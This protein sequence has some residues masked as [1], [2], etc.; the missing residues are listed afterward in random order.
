MVDILYN[1]MKNLCPKKPRTY[2]KKARKGYLPIA[3]QRRPPSKQK[4]NGD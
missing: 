1:S 4:K 3:K 2:R